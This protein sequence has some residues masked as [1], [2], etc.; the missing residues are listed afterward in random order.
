MQAMRDHFWNLDKVDQY[1]WLI[2]KLK[3]AASAGV[4]TQWSLGGSPFCCTAWCNILHVGKYR[5]NRI[6]EAI[7]TSERPYPYIDQRVYN[8]GRDPAALRR[9]DAFWE[10]AYQNM[11]EPLADARTVMVDMMPDGELVFPAAA[12]VTWRIRSWM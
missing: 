8:Q 5:L 1:Q 7:R 10:F 6:R 4:A 2:D 12:R 11:A 3:P 9:A